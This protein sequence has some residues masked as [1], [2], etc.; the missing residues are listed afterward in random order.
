MKLIFID[1]KLLKTAIILILVGETSII[2]WTMMALLADVMQRR[3]LGPLCGNIGKRGILS[4]GRYQYKRTS[5]MQSLV[6]C[7]RA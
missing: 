7:F 4:R 5:Y 6:F 1:P 2:A 3:P